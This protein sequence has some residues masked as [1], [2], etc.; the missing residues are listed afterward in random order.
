MEYKCYVII[1]EPENSDTDFEKVIILN[2]V[3]RVG[4]EYMIANSDYIVSTSTGLGM[5]TNCENFLSKDLASCDFIVNLHIFDS[6]SI[7]EKEKIHL[8]NQGWKKIN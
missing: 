6:I 5:M 2:H 1:S 7:D 3:P 4:Q 8:I